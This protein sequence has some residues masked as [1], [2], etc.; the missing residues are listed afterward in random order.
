MSSKDVFAM[1]ANV[2]ECPN[3]FCFVGTFYFCRART[4]S[5][6]QVSSVKNLEN[7][8][9]AIIYWYFSIV[10]K[11]LQGQ[12]AINDNFLFFYKMNDTFTLPSFIECTFPLKLVV[13]II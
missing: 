4:V 12:V 1:V 11:K 13:K 7:H 6:A 3:N 10:E 5:I 9:A 8:G 2:S